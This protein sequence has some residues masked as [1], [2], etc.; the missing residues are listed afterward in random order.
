[1]TDV[2]SHVGIWQI[3]NMN[4][5]RLQ[6][7]LTVT[8]LLLAGSVES[9]TRF[10]FPIE[11]EPVSLA[12]PREDLNYRLP[13]NTIPSHYD[14][15]LTTRVDE[16][17]REFT[18]VVT[19]DLTVV[20]ETNSIVLNARQLSFTTATIQN[21]NESPEELNIEYES[22]REFLIL[23]RQVE[24][25]FAKNSQLKLS[26]NYN[27]VLRNDNAGFYMT[28]YTDVDGNE[29]PLAATQFESTNARHAFPCYDDPGKRATF[30]VTI[31]HSPAYTAI[32]NMP[33]D[34][35]ATTNGKTVFQTTPNMPTYL[36]AFIVSD[37]KYSE[38]ELN[39]LRQRLYSRPGSENEQEWGLL[40]GMLITARL[41]EYFD[42]EFALP[43]LDQ[44]A[45]PNKGGAM[46]NWGMATYGEQY[47]LYN[48]GHSTVNT[49]TSVAN[50][51]AHE[52]CHQ[53]FGDYVTIQWWTYLW[54]KE[55][56]AELFSWKA[57]DE[58]FPEWGIWQ[59]YH[60]DDYQSALNS[61]ASDNPRP[62]TNYVQTPAEISSLYDD[63][64][65]AKAGSVLNMWNHALTDP[66]FKRGLHN[67]LDA[68]Q[69][70]SAKEGDL[71]D[72]IQIA[73]KEE[74]YAVP[75]LI[76]D[77]MGSWTH[78]GGYPLLTV[79]RNYED[80]SFT[81]SQKA[82]FDNPDKESN[83]L[84]Y[85]PINY[86]SASKADFR[87][88]EASD[89]LLKVSNIT[90]DAKL[91]KDDWLILNKQSTGFYRINYDEENW[92]LIIQGLVEKPYK[93]HP[94]NRAQ[95]MHDAYRF[96]L[97]NG[98]PHSTL[99]EMLTYLVNED[100]YA[101]WATAK[102]IFDTFHRYFINDDNY[103][104]FRA[105]LAYIV[106]PAY[107][108]FGVNE[109]AG[110]QHYHKYTR[111]IIIHLACM[112]GIDNYCQE[113]HKKFEDEVENGVTIEPNLQ[114]QIYCVALK[115]GSNKQFNYVFDKLMS[116]N[117][118]ALRNSY[119]SSLGCAESDSHLNTFL[120][121]SID[122]NNKLRISERL[123]I[124]S[125]AYSR[126]QAGLNAAIEFLNNNWQDYGDLG[127]GSNKP[128]DAA[129]RGMA[130]YVVNSDQEAK[131]VKLVDKVKSSNYVNS[132]LEM[133]VKSK[134]ESN[135]NWLMSNR[136]PFLSWMSNFRTSGS[137]SLTLS[138]VSLATV[139]LTFVLRWF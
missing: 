126:S 112:A 36:V 101:P 116:S 14:I 111:N 71:F 102:G 108:K 130:T 43:K 84:W 127:T 92:K 34:E 82:F 29:R 5:G 3:N 93:V 109:D 104:A 24:T 99:L 46:E 31:N 52:Y 6:V 132:D 38:G 20:E 114:S 49:Q 33:V 100:Q 17:I 48:P 122:G 95:L 19:I 27:G 123:A 87:D 106:Q 21:G 70:T 26:V 35:T 65:Y 7:V 128:L 134:I 39:G 105:Y 9:A 76:E 137:T 83:N 103:Y 98:L 91:S 41:A 53:W 45:I 11:K 80:G 22:Q 85:I 62:M 4:G 16:G 37:F 66:V 121:S 78:Q 110:E 1:M 97:S 61:D 119:I 75:A 13:N 73:A 72:A 40:S 118:Q 58:A 120:S 54:L 94:R 50:I 133:A 28:T 77:M 74:N 68:N 124:L 131:L 107:E 47:L 96:T 139:L 79:G 44:A 23:T 90:V 56:F 59:Q 129:I 12:T 81:V 89:Y 138:M 10:K 32:S 57:T 42:V 8:I 136:D 125:A 113:V 18:G 63:V 2:H 15:V 60:V 30:T 135:Y 115:E 86:A 88:T 51:I 69:F 117:D 67:Y 25:P 64:S 55:G